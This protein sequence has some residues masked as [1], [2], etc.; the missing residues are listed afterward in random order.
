MTHNMIHEQQN[1]I[2]KG[3]G[4]IV[5]NAENPDALRRWMIASPE[6]LWII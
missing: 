6:M 2:I 5:V 1:A 4:G 3:D